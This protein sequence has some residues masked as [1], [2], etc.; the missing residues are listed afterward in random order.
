MF[1]NGST[2]ETPS[3]VEKFP[4][5]PIRYYRSETNLGVNPAWN[6]CMN[7]V[8][9]DYVAILNNDILFADYT[10]ELV[11]TVLHDLSQ[12]GIC[13]PHEVKD[14]R[15]LLNTKPKIPIVS[16]RN[17]K[18]PGFHYFIR[19]DLWSSI[20]PISDNVLV[21]YGDNHIW[22][23]SNSL[24]YLNV[25]CMNAPIFHYGGATLYNHSDTREMLNKDRGKRYNRGTPDLFEPYRHF[26]EEGIRKAK[27]PVV[28]L[29]LGVGGGQ[30]ARM[31]L[32]IL[33][34][35]KAAF[36]DINPLCKAED[37]GD[38]DKIS[39]VK[40]SFKDKHVLD[41]FEKI[42]LLHVDVDP[43]SY[44]DTKEILSL[45]L[46]KMIDGGIILFHDASPRKF[47]VNQAL[48]ESGQEVTFCLESG[49]FPEAAP[50]MLI[51]R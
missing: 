8:E 17:G 45:Y 28:F 5:L 9:S 42:S 38:V 30:S 7:L 11:L 4:K 22:N 18:V 6:Y 20:G 29:E 34:D 43:H 50:A 25:E 47:G 12:V 3:L 26:Y 36:V 37:L 49:R 10:I 40:G 14:K 46:P 24:G 35:Y 1:D 39:I 2:D 31:F 27:Q 41:L 44:T 15:E 13:I 48:V 21:W 33:V 19:R 32:E 51:K 16:E 23:G